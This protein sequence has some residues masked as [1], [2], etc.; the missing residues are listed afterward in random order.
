MIYKDFKCKKLSMLGMGC[1]RFPCDKNGEVDFE[2]T[3]EMI[4]L[5]IKSGVNYFDTAWFYHEG[6]SEE[7]IGKILKKYDRESFYLATK[8]PGNE[9]KSREDVE[10]VFEKQLEKTGVD[11][12]DFY[13]FHN[14]C[15]SNINLF[16][17]EKLGI[18][19]YL[20]EQKSKGRIRHLGFSTHG[21]LE[22]MEDFIKKYGEDLEFCQIQLNWLDWT[23]QEA[24]EKVE[25]LNKYNLPVWVMEPL[26]GGKL[27]SLSDEDEK[28]LKAA[29]PSESI[30]AW[31]FRF[32]QSIDNIKMVLSGMS[33]R[34]Q[35][36]ENIKTFGDDLPLDEGEKNLLF[37][38]A[39]KI[40][41]KKTL[42]CT[43]CKY[44]ISE[45]PNELE[46]PKL[47]SLYNNMCLIKNE[48]SEKLVREK[49]ENGKMPMDCIGC[50]S[51]ESKCPQN[52]QISG[53]MSDF[54]EKLQSV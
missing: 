14:V 3:S 53:I 39:E 16:T 50:G 7:I 19:E 10:A 52:I 20:K 27:A 29:R 5:C 40:L 18:C 31:S 45:C 43:N 21:S 41:S 25:L 54:A 26:R 32:L 36:E 9:F 44:C 42:T 8:M 51:C 37:V 30:P 49:T 15:E 22:L 46:I 13:L 34:V 23:L 6:K 24:K 2:K 11:Y 1:M 12:F 33:E 4:D 38:I 35:V 17:D 28:V 48:P 47:L